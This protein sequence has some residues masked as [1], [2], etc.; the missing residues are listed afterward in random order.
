MDWPGRAECKHVLRRDT[1]FRILTNDQWQ[2][3]FETCSVWDTK[4][5]SNSYKK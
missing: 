4:Q 1:E 3:Q 5:M 2:R